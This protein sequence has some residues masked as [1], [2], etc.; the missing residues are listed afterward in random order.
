MCAGGGRRREGEEMS[1][2]RNGGCPVKEVVLWR[3]GTLSSQDAG[4][5]ARKRRV[6]SVSMSL[7]KELPSDMSVPVPPNAPDPYSQSLS[8]SPCIIQEA[9]TAVLSANVFIRY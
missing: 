2:F 9:N 1:S 8:L 7:L 4:R 6:L 5:Q 3:G